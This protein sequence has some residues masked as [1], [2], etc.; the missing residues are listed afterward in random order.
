MATVNPYEAEI[1]RRRR[2]LEAQS[3]MLRKGGLTPEQMAV[4]V[5][6]SGYDGSDRQDMMADMLR[7]GQAALIGGE[8]PQGKQMGAVYAGPTWS[9]ALNA[10]AQRAL[11]GYQMGEARREGRKIEKRQEAAL[12]AKE[13]IAAEQSRIEQLQA[14]EKQ[15]D[16]LVR[17]GLQN[18]MAKERLDRADQRAATQEAGRNQ[19]AAAANATRLSAANKSG[20]NS[21]L[22]AIK[23]EKA[24]I[25]LANLKNPPPKLSATERKDATANNATLGVVDS[26]LAQIEELEKQGKGTSGYRSLVVDTLPD[27]F[28]GISE[29]VFYDGDEQQQR[30]ANAYIDSVVKEAITTG[31]LSDQDQKRLAGLNVGAVG[32]TPAQQTQRLQAIKEI[33]GKYTLPTPSV[34][35]PANTAMQDAPSPISITTEAEYNALP[36]GAVYIDPDDGKKYRKP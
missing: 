18:A 28:K 32:I 4:L 9:E 36:S 11:G 17:Q 6:Q 34:P 33:M 30:A 20:G 31:V 21:E 27:A 19:R 12:K 10:A 23:L 16:A 1:A 8:L 2:E 25:E 13:G 3:A 26:S 35:P 14:V 22:D 7:T 15:Q 24:K 5:A 29:N